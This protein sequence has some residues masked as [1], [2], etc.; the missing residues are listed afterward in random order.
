M[1][2]TETWIIGATHSCLLCVPQINFDSACASCEL[3]VQLLRVL[4]YFFYICKM[5]SPYILSPSPTILQHLI[6]LFQSP[7]ACRDRSTTSNINLADF[8]ADDCPSAHYEEMLLSLKAQV[9]G[10]WKFG[11]KSTTCAIF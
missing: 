11:R 1:Q 2:N 3:S 10:V 6:G 8:S 4:S 9:D 5:C 7:P